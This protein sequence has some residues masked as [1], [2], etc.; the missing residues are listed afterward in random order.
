MRER[1]ES[2]AYNEK[3][4]P[5]AQSFKNQDDQIE[6]RKNYKNPL[7]EW[8]NSKNKDNKANKGM[9]MRKRYTNGGRF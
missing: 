2:G 5:L 3:V 8:F 9:K 6:N 1:Y 7:L 4:N